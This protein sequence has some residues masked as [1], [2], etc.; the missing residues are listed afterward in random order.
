VDVVVYRNGEEITLRVTLGQRELFEAAAR[1]DGAE[2]APE[3]EAA[4]ALLGMMLQPLNDALRAELDLP[5]TTSGLIV[6]EVEPDSDAAQ[7]GILPGDLITEANQQPVA[8][9]AD[10]EA[11]AEE[12]RDAGRRSVLVLLRREGD[13]RFVALSLE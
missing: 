2:T 4:S 12:A 10:L 13:P 1:R 8:S 7:K 6:R 3:P 9:L 11:R 5:A